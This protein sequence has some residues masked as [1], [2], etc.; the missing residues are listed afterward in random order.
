MGQDS[1]QLAVSTFDERETVLNEWRSLQT[2]LERLFSAAV[3]SVTV[4]AGLDRG[5]T[6]RRVRN[7]I[8]LRRRRDRIFGLGLFGEPA[9]DMLLELYAAEITGRRE[10][11]SGR[12]VSG[13]PAT[14]ALR[15]ITLLENAGWIARRADQL[16][17]RR[18]FLSLTPKAT[19]AMDS[20]FAQPELVQIMCNSHRVET[21]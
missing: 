15:W 2:R 18:S 5:E 10:C 8:R 13:V 9:W 20:F 21:R 1:Q 12:C 4:P 6:E 17:R 3:H 14:T 19:S 16:D 11:V 7:I